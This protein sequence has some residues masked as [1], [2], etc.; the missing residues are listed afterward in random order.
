VLATNGALHDFDR[1]LVQVLGQDRL[2]FR[3]LPTAAAGIYAYHQQLRR[4][5][6]ARKRSVK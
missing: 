3:E 6:A 1:R 5:I 4:E 2:T